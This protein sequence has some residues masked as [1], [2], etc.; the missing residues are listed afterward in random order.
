MELNKTMDR[1]QFTT[2]AAALAALAGVTITIGCGSG[3]SPTSSSAGTGGT[4]GTGSTTSADKVGTISANHGH[5]AVITAARLAAGGDLSLD[6]QGQATHPHTVALSA[7]ELSSVAAGQRV[8]KES[9]TDSAH[10]H[11]VTFN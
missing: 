1:R 7:A 5:S 8:S 2:L 6:I 9:S 4:G 3:S 11:T 10:S